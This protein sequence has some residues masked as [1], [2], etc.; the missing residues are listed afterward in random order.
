MTPD[1]AFELL[2]A[3]RA[4]IWHSKRDLRAA[5][6]ALAV[7][8]QV[9][10]DD[11]CRHLEAAQDRAV[12]AEQERDELRVELTRELDRRTSE[13]ADALEAYAAAVNEL[14]RMRDQ[15]RYM[16]AEVAELQ[17]ALIVTSKGA[18]A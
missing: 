3:D 5:A 4:G 6:Y 16:T 12:L 7:A 13:T 9:R 8:P 17:H 10:F 18:P 11:L 2:A 1:M 15:V 14:E